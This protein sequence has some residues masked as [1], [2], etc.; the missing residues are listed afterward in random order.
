MTTSSKR[1]KKFHIQTKI[2]GHARVCRCKEI[3]GICL[4]QEI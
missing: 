4:I 1:K 2:Y 3:V